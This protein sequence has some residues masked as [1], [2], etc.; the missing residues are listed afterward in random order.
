LDGDFIIARRNPKIRQGAIGLCYLGEEQE[1]TVKR[2]RWGPDGIE[3]I[4]ENPALSP[5]RVRK[6]DPHFRIGGT[7]VGVVRRIG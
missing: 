7:V 2:F 3:L 5:I 4:P 1:A 6:D